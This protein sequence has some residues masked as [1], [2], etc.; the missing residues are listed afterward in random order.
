MPSRIA[1]S[2]EAKKMAEQ[3]L[4]DVLSSDTPMLV[5]ALRGNTKAKDDKDAATTF[6]RTVTLKARAAAAHRLH[7]CPYVT[8][9]SVVHRRRP[10]PR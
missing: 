10:R 7:A 3:M 2:D 9:A 6:L 8:R 4:S 5:R 1:A